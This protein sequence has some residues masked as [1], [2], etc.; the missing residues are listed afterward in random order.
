M[1]VEMIKPAL[2]SG[3]TSS[4]LQ[5][6]LATPIVTWAGLP[7]FQ[8]GWISL[9]TWRLNMFTLV[10]I[11]VGTA[12]GYSVVATLA[13]G[14]FPMSIRMDGAVPVYYEAAGVVVALVLLGQVLELRA[15]ASTG[16]AIR[17]LLDL[18]P[19]RARRIGADG[20]ETD[21]A[22]DA[23][24]AGDRLRV[25]P[26]E[27]IPVDGVVTEGRSLVNEAMFTGEATPVE[28]QSG[29][30]VIGGSMN[31]AGGL[32]MTAQAVGRD[33]ML[34]RIVEMV[35][36]AQRSR[37]PIQGVADKVAAWFVPAVVAVAA[38]T[39]AVWLLVGPQPRLSHALLNAI[40]VLIIA[41]P[42]ALG[43][44]TPMSIMV[45][46]GRGAK[47]GG[48]RQECRSPAGLGP[49]RYVGGRQDRYPYRGPPGPDRHQG[50]GRDG[51][52]PSSG[53]SRRG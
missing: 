39:F 19:K 51:G 4:W 35:A 24:A 14:L 33:T 28:K 20:G 23:L 8:R 15:R 9:R 7:F 17:A 6:L 42:C 36:Q 52:K 18:A 34:A 27:A 37:A 2:I 47:A 21:V 29:D 49:R 25:R 40:A 26:G 1:V 53:A 41:C 3:A 44:A 13:P 31:G 12:Y 48:A 11:G 30:K 43:L 46:I 50:H 38:I 16:R 22:L 10:S 5:F 45:G 32:I